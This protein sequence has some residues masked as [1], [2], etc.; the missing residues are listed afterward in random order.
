MRKNLLNSKIENYFDFDFFQ[1]FKLSLQKLL[2]F[3]IDFM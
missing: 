1:I 3:G 2:I